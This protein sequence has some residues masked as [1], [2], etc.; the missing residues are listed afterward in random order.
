MD[1]AWLLAL[2]HIK[3]ANGDR[4]VQG[5][6]W[7]HK[8]VY[9][10]SRYETALDCGFVPERFGMFSRSLEDALEWCI[11]KGLICKD[12]SDNT[13]KSPLYLSSI[14]EAYIKN[15]IE[16]LDSRT[17]DILYKIKSALNGMTYNELIAFCYTRYPEMLENT[18]ERDRY[19]RSR[20][21][22]AVSSFVNGKVTTAMAARIAGMKS[23]EFEKRLLEDGYDL[24][25][26]DMKL[27]AW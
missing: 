2:L 12:S 18:T 10:A 19:E 26:I 1:K 13:A 5:K 17:L 3:D 23:W 15:R 16:A 11:Q 24:D 27:T 25:K 14:G 6:T 9:V 21:D 22:A 7:L 8:I 20:W 4:A